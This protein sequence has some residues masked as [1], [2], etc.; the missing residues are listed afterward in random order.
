MQAPAKKAFLDCLEI[1]GLRLQWCYIHILLLLCCDSISSEHRGAR[2]CFWPLLTWVSLPT[3]KRGWCCRV[4][5]SLPPRSSC[6]GIWAARLTTRWNRCRLLSGARI[7]CLR[8]KTPGR[9][10][11][12]V[13]ICKSVPLSYIWARCCENTDTQSPS[14]A[15]PSSSQST[16]QFPSLTLPWKQSCL[17]SKPHC[18][19]PKHGR[20]CWYNGERRNCRVLAHCWSNG[21]PGHR[22]SQPPS[23]LRCWNSRT[24]FISREIY[25]FR[26]E[27]IDFRLI[28][29]ARTREISSLHTG[30]SHFPSLFLYPSLQLHG[31]CLSWHP[32]AKPEL[33]RLTNSYT[34]Q[35]NT[36]KHI[37]PLL[38]KPGWAA[39][40]KT[41]VSRHCPWVLLTHPSSFH[42]PMGTSSNKC[43]TTDCYR[44]RSR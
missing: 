33:H 30:W 24:M 14:P 44:I 35:S 32:L 31:D 22:T 19:E 40:P 26:A 13:W 39:A 16:M 25:S 23:H 20:G 29:G 27:N 3:P 10:D 36:S 8:M 43:R 7:K 15:L 42:S 37:N 18:F 41:E 17:P 2:P 1:C 28:L 6:Q 4:R 21:S 5:C 9:Q 11:L 38:A 34:R 12:Q